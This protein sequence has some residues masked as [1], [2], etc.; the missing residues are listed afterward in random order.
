MSFTVKYEN[1]GHLQWRICFSMWDNL[2]INTVVTQYTD[3]LTFD[4][5]MVKLVQSAVHSLL[6]NSTTG[7]LVMTGTTKW[8]KLVTTRGYE[9]KHLTTSPIKK[10]ITCFYRNL[11]CS[12]TVAVENTTKHI[13]KN[14]YKNLVWL[15]TPSN[16]FFFDKLNSAFSYKYQRTTNNLI[17]RGA[18]LQFVHYSVQLHFYSCTKLW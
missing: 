13:L 14:I 10:E 6:K 8:W 11:L 5:F 15:C 17:I 4:H 18:Y 7:C 2:R 3:E 9:L 12:V 16:I 1:S